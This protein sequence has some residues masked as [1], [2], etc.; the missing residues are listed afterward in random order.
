MRW[1]PIWVLYRK[2]ACDSLLAMNSTNT[3]E[4]PDAPTGKMAH[5]TPGPWNIHSTYDGS[6]PWKYAT[7]EAPE[8]ED[9]PGLGI[10]YVQS[11]ISGQ[12]EANARLIAAAPEL[13]HALK[14]AK[15]AL[16]RLTGMDGVMF[17]ALEKSTL[18]D[19]I[20]SAIAKA[21]KGQS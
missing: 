19:L 14:R 3:K 6:L 12:D 5:H 15:S 18:R 10:C 2:P 7:I 9:Q 8:L 16:A 21:E 4:T 20:E 1:A 13:L 17:S 11:L